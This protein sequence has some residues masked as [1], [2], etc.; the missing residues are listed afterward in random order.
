MAFIGPENSL[1]EGLFKLIGIGLFWRQRFLATMPGMKD[2]NGIT[3][4]GVKNAIVVDD[5]MTD[6]FRKEI[7][8]RRQWAT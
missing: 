6:F 8:F 4:S 3:R 2:V 1:E 7:V 5:Q